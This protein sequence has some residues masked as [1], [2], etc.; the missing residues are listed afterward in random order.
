[1][2]SEKDQLVMQTA[3]SVYDFMGTVGVDW[4]EAFY[5]YV[6][7]NPSHRSSQLTF[8]KARELSFTDGD[9]GEER[10]FIREI[11]GFMKDLN[12]L[13]EQDCNERPIVIVVCVSSE[14]DYKLSFDY[15]SPKVLDT[16]I[17][18]LGSK[19]SFFQNNEIDIPDFD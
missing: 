12:S 7:Y 13:I 10:Q 6:E 17:M 4:D 16:S 5:R 18:A 11:E 1:M 15:K 8:R 14:G 19:N 2:T 3:K 9:D